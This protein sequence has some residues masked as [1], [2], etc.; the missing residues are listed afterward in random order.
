MASKK[1]RVFVFKVALKDAKRIWRR[2]A[3]RGDQTLDELHCAIYDAFDRYD[4]HL[5]SFY[6]FKPRVAGA[7]KRSDVAFEFTDLITAEEASSFADHPMYDASKTT[8]QSLNLVAGKTF[9]Y[10]FDF[11][12]EW[13]HELTVDKTDD[14]PDD[15]PYPRVI[16]KKGESPPQYPDLD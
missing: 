16:E 14:Q 15:K 13:W 4:A 1:A 12:D 11:G 9:E 6:F 5:Y 3:I 7:R 10:L 2:I 8:I